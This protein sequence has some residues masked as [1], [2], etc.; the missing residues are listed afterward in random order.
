MPKIDLVQISSSR[1]CIFETVFVCFVVVV[2]VLYQVSF[3][4]KKVYCFIFTNQHM[5]FFQLVKPS[6]WLFSVNSI[7]A[8]KAKEAK[9]IWGKGVNKAMEFLF[10]I[11]Y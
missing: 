10:H 11:L 4:F 8:C 6:C 9:Q 5:I 1:P 2:V 3:T 7:Q